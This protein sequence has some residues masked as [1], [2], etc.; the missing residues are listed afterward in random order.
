MNKIAA[1]FT[2]TLASTIVPSGAHAGFLEKFTT[3]YYKIEVCNHSFRVEKPSLKVRGQRWN[4]IS[5]EPGKCKVLEFKENSNIQFNDDI[6]RIED[7]DFQGIVR[8]AHP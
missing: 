5:F 7:E 8:L 4:P 1:F 3:E 2:L 6:Y